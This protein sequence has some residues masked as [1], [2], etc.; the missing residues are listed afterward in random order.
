[1]KFELNCESNFDEMRLHSLNI[2]FSFSREENSKS[3]LTS[4]AY[5]SL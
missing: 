1:M 4:L 3:S 5:L 2:D